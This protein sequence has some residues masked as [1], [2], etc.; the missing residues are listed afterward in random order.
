MELRFDDGDF[1]NLVCL[2]GTGVAKTAMRIRR[3]P[4]IRNRETQKEMEC[5][6]D[7]KEALRENGEL[8]LRDL[9]SSAFSLCNMEGK[10]PQKLK[11][12]GKHLMV[13]I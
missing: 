11:R 6:D 5:F 7:P 3:V 9:G 12:L 8:Q 4:V 13:W 10:T 2:S 1:A